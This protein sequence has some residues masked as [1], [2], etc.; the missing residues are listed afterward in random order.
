MLPLV[1]AVIAVLA[2]TSAPSPATVLASVQ[3]YY[4]GAKQL[5]TKFQQTVVNPAYGTTQKSTGKVYLVSPDKMRWDYDAKKQGGAKKSFI[6]DGKTLW[7]VEPKNLQVF[8]SSASGSMLPAALS[9][10]SGTAQLTKEFDVTLA[11]NSPYGATVLELSPKQP[12]AQYKR[13]Y[14]VVASDGHVEKSIVID[15]ND[16]SNEIAFAVHDLT[17]KLDGKLFQFDP[18][19]VP[20]FKVIDV[21]TKK[22]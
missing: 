17:T 3:K 16:N 6:C 14:F 8:K 13:L 18:K 4:G 22:P 12:S 5:T 2:P 1:F 15:A 19:S 7:A 11:P 21:D 20:T 9:F 10:A